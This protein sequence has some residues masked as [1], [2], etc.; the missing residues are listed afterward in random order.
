[1]YRSLLRS[2]SIACRICHPIHST[3]SRKLN[4]LRT[5]APECIPSNNNHA[6]LFAYPFSLTPRSPND[7]MRP[8]PRP[9]KTVVQ[10]LTKRSVH[11]KT[12]DMP[13]SPLRSA[14]FILF[15]HGCC[16]QV[17]LA[18]HRAPK[19]REG[20]KRKRHKDIPCAYRDRTELYE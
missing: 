13:A 8:T 9:E 5:V 19:P 12:P 3:Y 11:T 20:T 10:P 4:H 7:R 1:M 18:T 16:S 14:T 17:D 2:S 6:R 15:R